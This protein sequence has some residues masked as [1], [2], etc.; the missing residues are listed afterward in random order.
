VGGLFVVLFLLSLYSHET[1]TAA[2]F[3]VNIISD[4]YLAPLA[5]SV[6]EIRKEDLKP[7]FRG[8]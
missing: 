6:L 7:Y 5:I 8:V 1:T 2:I 3:L 4:L